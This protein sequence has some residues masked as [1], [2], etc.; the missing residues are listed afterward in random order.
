MGRDGKNGCIVLYVELVSE[1]VKCRNFSLLAARIERAQARERGR[2]KREEG[3]GKRED[4][5]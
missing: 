5:R 3:R 1:R 4:R 2:E